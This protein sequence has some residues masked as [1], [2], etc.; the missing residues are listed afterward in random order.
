MAGKVPWNRTFKGRAVKVPDKGPLPVKKFAGGLQLVILGPTT[1]KLRILRPVWVEA[2]KEAGIKPGRPAKRPRPPGLESFGPLNVETLAAAKFRED[3][4]EANGSSIILLLRYAGTSILLGADGH[5][6]V[7][8][9]A[10]KRLSPTRRLALDAYKVAHHGSKNNVNRT[11][12]ERIK[13]SRYLFSSSGSIYRHPDREAV[14]RVL[15]FGKSGRS[16]TELFFNYRTKFNRVWDNAA[17][18]TKWGYKTVF[19]RS[20]ENGLIVFEKS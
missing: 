4:T 11:L 14:A 3:S 13:C 17:L 6:S 5:P 7:I 19:P 8:E 2:C 18:K 1:K 15:K 16:V 20:G 10:I 12:L 9:A